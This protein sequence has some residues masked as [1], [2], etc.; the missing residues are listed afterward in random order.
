[1]NH[2]DISSPK[3]TDI[4][5]TDIGEELVSVRGII[6]L[7]PPP[8]SVETR[9]HYHWVRKEVLARLQ[10][11][12]TLL[13]LGLKLRLYEGYRSPQFQHTL[14]QEQL[15]RVFVDNPNLSERE[16]YAIAARLVAPIKTYDGIDLYPPHSTGGAVDV[17]IMDELGQVI[18]FGMEI[19][20]WSRVDA[21]LCQTEVVGLSEGA[22]KNRALLISVME[23]AGFVN[24]SR[25]WWH[26]SYGDQYWACLT[27]QTHAMYSSAGAGLKR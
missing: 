11:A 15:N 2:I 21:S 10:R 26:F 12:Q 17:E 3:V 22:K 1:M 18:D 8:E 24:Y 6:E 25:E 16:A 20:D 4:P 5:V 19:K 14:F 7:G 9:E 23:A 13:P 27:G